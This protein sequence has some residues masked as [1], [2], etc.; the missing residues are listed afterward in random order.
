M[1]SR[2]VPYRTRP[3]RKAGK[4]LRAQQ[5]S[6]SFLE[7][8]GNE[9][10]AGLTEELLRVRTHPP[11]VR[12]ADG[13]YVGDILGFVKGLRLSARL[14]YFLRER[15]SRTGQS[16]EVSW[17]HVLNKDGMACSP[18]CD[19]IVHRPGYVRCWNG[20][21]HPVM[22]FR[23]IGSDSVLA[24]IS[25]KSHATSV[26][27]AYPK[28]LRAFGVKH[29]FLFAECC[30]AKHLPRLRKAAKSA[31]YAGLWC[32]YQMRSSRDSNIIKDEAM[33]SG[34]GRAVETAVT[35]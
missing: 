10:L 34:F 26:D 13:K 27:A 7:T 6:A 11:L 29:V 32:L 24:V 21:D 33:W 19:I 2:R 15:L 8:L 5:S 30:L 22:H 1:T 14:I 28:S 35:A 4:P 18:E 31:G 23:F 25:C 3:K 16:L 20:S 12:R 17:G 9:Q